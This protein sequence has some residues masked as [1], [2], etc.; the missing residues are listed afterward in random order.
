MP[1]IT[2]GQIPIISQIAMSG[3]SIQIYI[4]YNFEFTRPMRPSHPRL[5]E[6]FRERIGCVPLLAQNVVKRGFIRLIQWQILAKTEG[7]VR[8]CQKDD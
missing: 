5:Q 3:C 7:E 1:S 4:I 6:L 8:L 2:Y